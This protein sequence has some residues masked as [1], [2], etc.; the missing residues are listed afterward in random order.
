MDGSHARHCEKIIVRCCQ[1]RQC[2][3]RPKP[4]KNKGPGSSVWRAPACLRSPEPLRIYMRRSRVNCSEFL[5]WVQS[6]GRCCLILHN[7]HTASTHSSLFQRTASQKWQRIWSGYKSKSQNKPIIVCF[8]VK[9]LRGESCFNRNIWRI[10]K[11]KRMEAVWQ[12][13]PILGLYIL[14]RHGAFFLNRAGG[15]P[16][17]TWNFHTFLQLPV[18]L[19]NDW[20]W[21]SFSGN[22]RACSPSCR[23]LKRP[24]HQ[25]RPRLHSSW[26]T[27]AKMCQ[28]CYVSWFFFFFCKWTVPSRL[29]GLGR[30]AP[31]YIKVRPDLA[32]QMRF[33][34]TSSG[35][36]T[37][38][39]PPPRPHK[40]STWWNLQ[41]TKMPE[42]LT[43]A[44][45]RISA[46]T[47]WPGRGPAA[48]AAR[49]FQRLPIMRCVGERSE[50]GR[51]PNSIFYQTNQT[52]DRPCLPR[53]H[54]FLIFSV[55]WFMP[56]H[57]RSNI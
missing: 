39:S 46:W 34:L 57:L 32:Y 10:F 13:M 51:A 6:R 30:T 52:F 7:K 29:S 43:L 25:A 22:V 3:G 1:V 50:P 31:V 18:S 49:R 27:K 33:G 17:K 54:Q 44:M 8:I 23:R 53:A 48:A 21:I 5:R 26:W 2:G 42:K 37:V 15:S 38:G 16:R 45:V 47:S 12:H 4:W 35:H 28:G 56:F 40:S 55:H 41:Q 11:R 19:E 14:H 24:L 20:Y 9:Q 36:Q